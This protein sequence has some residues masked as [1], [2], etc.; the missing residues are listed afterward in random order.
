MLFLLNT[1]VQ[2]FLKCFTSFFQFPL[3]TKFKECVRLRTRTSDRSILLI[4]LVSVHSKNN[5]FFPF[6]ND[7]KLY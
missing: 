5:N 6:I 1:I 2:L 3:L 7:E 4:Y